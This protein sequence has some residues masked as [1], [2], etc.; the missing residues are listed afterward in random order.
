MNRI[1]GPSGANVLED[2]YKKVYNPEEPGYQAMRASLKKLADYAKANDIRLTLAMMPDIHDLENYRF[3]WIHE[4][5]ADLAQ[6]M[7]YTF[8]DLLP[9]FAGLNPSE[10]WAM[11]GDPHPNARGHKLMADAIYPLL[12]QTQ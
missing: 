4:H 6:K 2:H 1:F 12:K 3:G 5:M 10:V 8:V 7:G 9:A 11:A